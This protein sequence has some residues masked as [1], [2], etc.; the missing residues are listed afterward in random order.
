MF[1]HLMA[2]NRSGQL[3]C[4]MCVFCKCHMKAD[5]GHISV[6]CCSVETMASSGNGSLRD[7][8]GADH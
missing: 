8:T 5:R 7:F 4:S 1:S 3:C 2:L 6:F